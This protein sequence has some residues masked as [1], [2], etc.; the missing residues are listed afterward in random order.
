[1]FNNYR[2][3]KTDIKSIKELIIGKNE[4]LNLVI[5]WDEVKYEFLVNLKDN[6]E[7]LIVLGSGAHD[8]KKGDKPPIIQRHSWINDFDESLI[9][10]N[11]PTLYLGE[12]NLGWGY[13]T[14]ERH[15]IEEIS[16]ILKEI[17]I[18]N[19]VRNENVFFYGSSGG[20]FMS[21]MLA[22]L[23]KG[24][25]AIVNNPQTIVTN[26]FKPLV[27][28]MYDAVYD[29]NSS[30]FKSFITSRVNLIEFFKLN[31]YVPHIVYTQNLAS[32]HDIERHL[33]PF[34]KELSQ[35][36]DKLFSGKIN[37]QYYMNKKQGHNPLDKEDTLKFIRKAISDNLEQ[38]PKEMIN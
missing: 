19:S 23:V 24:S 8:P 26:Y 32:K 36:D 11:D 15:Y 2:T 33:T 29:D 20:G 34:I 10:Y 1:M 4:P 37:M 7:N 14:H 17:F 31:Q 6:T 21:A 16:I 3:I 5:Q 28:K 12:M 25:T 38:F 9:Y 13:G 30:D 22:C 18:K 27:K 35:L